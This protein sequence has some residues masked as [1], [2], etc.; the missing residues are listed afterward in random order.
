MSQTVQ[1]IMTRLAGEALAL[2]RRVK[3]SS[4]T[5]VYSDADEKAIGVTVISAAIGAPV[6]VEIAGGKT[7]KVCASAAITKDASIYAR[8]DG[9]VDDAGAGSD[10][11]VIGVCLETA[12]ADGDLVECILNAVVA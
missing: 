2:G 5:F 4:G 7:Q 10:S 11:A 9:K 12:L 8:A 1:N 3:L 6:A